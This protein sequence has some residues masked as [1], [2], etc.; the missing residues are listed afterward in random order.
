MCDF[1]F[2]IKFNLCA[3]LLKISVT[4]LNSLI[5]KGDLEAIPGR[6]GKKILVE[7]LIRYLGKREFLRKFPIECSGGRMKNGIA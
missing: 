1:P 4:N 7:S 5:L 2:S 3:D 6:D